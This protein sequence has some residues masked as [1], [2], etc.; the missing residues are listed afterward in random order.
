MNKV[1]KVAVALTGALAVGA[2]AYAVYL[3]RKLQKEI[4]GEYGLDKADSFDEDDQFGEPLGGFDFHSA[5]DTDWGEGLGLDDDDIMTDSDI[6]EELSLEDEESEL[7]E[8][9]E[10]VTDDDFGGFE[11]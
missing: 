3:E 8:D 6:D 1:A 11:M 9:C 7:P 5:E 4:E 2:V 10:E